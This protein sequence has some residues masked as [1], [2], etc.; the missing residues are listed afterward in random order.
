MDHDA[1]RRR[2]RVVARADARA[3]RGHG[4]DLER[5][6][7]TRAPSAA[8][9]RPSGAART[10]S[11]G[12]SGSRRGATKPRSRATPAPS[13]ASAPPTTRARDSDSDR[14]H[15]CEVRD[16]RLPA[17]VGPL[18]VDAAPNGGI[19]V[20]AWDQA[21]VLVRA[22]VNTWA[23]DDAEARRVLAQRARHAAGADVSAEGPAA[24]R[25]PPAPRL[26]GQLP[27]L[28]AAQTALALTGR[29]GGV[30][31]ARHA[32]RLALHHRQRR[33]HPRPGRAAASSARPRN[34]G[35]NVRLSGAR[36]EGEGLDVETTN[37][38]V[39]LAIPAGYFG[40]L[41]PARSMAACA[42]TFRSR[43]RAGGDREMRATLGSGGP[44][45]QGDAPSTAACAS[46]SADCHRRQTR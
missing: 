17:P 26:V 12:A 34:G 14:G 38:G 3:A 15:A 35:V 7:L 9:S 2:P 29:N 11:A 21:D 42:P 4:V 46:P 27:H 23:D 20:E 1:R 41:E 8:A 36:W 33:R 13:A 5:Q 43:C 19:R 28:G 40:E 10:P 45:P 44:L 22:V 18:T 37:G 39:S 32:R 6:R 31:A 30:V 25:R 16:S 24:L